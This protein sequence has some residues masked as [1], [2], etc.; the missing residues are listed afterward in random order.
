MEERKGIIVIGMI[1]S[2]KS[3]FLNSL[4]GITYLE[5]KD[6][7][8]TKFVTIIRYNENLKEP[9]FYH[10]K[11]IK[12]EESKK[13]EKETKKDQEETKKD[14][15]QSKNDEKEKNEKDN[16]IIDSN[17]EDIK[18]KE[19]N[20]YLFE[21]DGEESIGADNIVKKIKE[22]NDEEKENQEPKYEN[23]FYMLETNITNIENKEFLKTHD[24][25]DIPGLNEYIIS[26]KKVDTEAKDD[27]KE[28]KK[29][30]KEEKKE[31]DE[32]KEDN[33]N[34]RI[35]TTEESQEDMRYIKGLFKFL[36]KKIEREIIIFSSETYYKPQNL[37]I[38]KEIKNEL[39]ITL[40]NNLIILNKIDICDDK[41]KTIADCKQFFVNNID[42]D[43]FNLFKNVFVPLNSM[44]FKNEILMKNN[45]E[46]YY[47]FY[48]N[49]YIDKYIRIKEEEEKKIVKIPFIEFII[50]EITNGKKKEEKKEFINSLANNFNDDNMDLIK[51]V[52]E[53]VKKNSN[54]LIDY[55]INFDVDEDEEDE[56]QSLIIIKAFYQNFE[57]KANFPKY[58]ENVQTILDYFNNFKDNQ[59]VMS[60]MEK[61]P[62]AGFTHKNPESQ[63]IEILK[64]IF[65]KLKKYVK[66]GDSD[67][68][69]NILSNNLIMMEKFILNDR[70]IY[71]PFIGVSSAGKSTILNCIVGYKLFPEAQNECTTRGIIIE[72]S[73][74]VELYETEID[75]ERNY[76]VFSPKKRVAEG[77]KDVR[78]YLKSLNYKY[79]KDESKHFFIV[80]TTI[81]SFDDFGFSQELKD[82]I[83]LVDLPGSDTKDNEFNK[84]GKHNRSVYEK[85]LSIS[86]SFI[87]INKGRAITETAN[88]TILKKLYTNIQDT[89]K[90][91]NNDYLKACLFAINLFTKVTE[92]ELNLEKI[93]KDLSKILFDNAENYENI[94]SVFFNAKNFYD[95]LVFSTLFQDHEASII[96]FEEEYKKNNDSSFLKVGSFSK[97]CLKQLKQKMKDLGIKYEDKVN[98]SP[99]FLQSFESFF[100]EKMKE[101]N[102]LKI[103]NNDK[104]NI[105]LLANIYDSL[106]NEEVYKDMDI[107][108][109]S[110]CH[111]FLENLKNQIELSKNYKDEEYIKKLKDSLQ[112][113][114]TFFAK[115]IKEDK[116]ESNTKKKFNEKKEELKKK[117]KENVDNFSL[118]EL[119]DEAKSEINVEINKSKTKLKDMLKEGK[120]TEEIINKVSSILNDIIKNF[121]SK[122]ENR[123]K[124]FNNKT[125]DLVEDIQKFSCLFNQLQLEKNEQ[126]KN[127][128]NQLINAGKEILIQKKTEEN[129]FDSLVK[130]LS[131]IWNS[132]KSF[133]NFFKGKEE[134]AMEKIEELKQDILD[135]LNSKERT[136]NFNIEDEKIKIKENFYAILALAFSDLSEIEEKEWIESKES[137]EKAKSFLLPD[138]KKENLEQE[139]KE[140][141][142]EEKSDVD[143]K[144]NKIEEIKDNNDKK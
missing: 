109:N 22:I 46:N 38:I 61:A 5:A 79:G 73:D 119:F 129:I 34:P 27:K 92:E 41:E 81:K 32:K 15:E 20:L 113:F 121:T 142:K 125:H 49:K 95:Y 26:D 126:Y 2:G 135:K 144:E 98:C 76:Y 66:E 33:S 112:I 63:A 45:Y 51:K 100:Y 21:Q 67:N 107:Y 47:L 13:D 28:Q 105:Q 139:K 96:K 86:S 91:G 24:F 88:Q 4:L 72:Y 134:V 37:Q 82:R 127:N 43:I 14:E 75:S 117:F 25:Y 3:T 101:L 115:D 30:H 124:Q 104:K 1:S 60:N 97:Y 122:L 137:Y 50:N 39:N 141:N 133:F 18:A 87:Y 131:Y 123:I 138:E 19:E 114:D 111:N 29:E 132:F 78:D 128:F 40:C 99:E 11:L 70:K 93:K 56:E 94:N 143:D 84:I 36:K 77:Y 52:Y 23:L 110:Y 7:V 55:G 65:D 17:V 16:I 103:S 10:L 48:L 120:Q 42:T 83:L 62:V 31:T 116:L 58:S 118:D 80:K 90:L 53:K 8:T 6:D 57:E 136:M 130:R 12:E 89:S 140:E 69:I 74:V 54:Y 44:Q 71:I 64:N 102:E 85:L 106:K 68:I 9:K 59:P 35:Q 108:K